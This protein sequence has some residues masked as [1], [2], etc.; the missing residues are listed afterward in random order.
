[1]LQF[2]EE[3]EEIVDWHPSRPWRRPGSRHNAAKSPR[4]S[5]LKPQFNGAEGR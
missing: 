5:R 3:T 1:L 2:P 4:F